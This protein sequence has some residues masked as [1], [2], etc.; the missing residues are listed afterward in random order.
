MKR[1]LKTSLLVLPLVALAAGPAAADVK[2][3]DKSQVKFEGFLGRMMGMFG[4][5]AA[6]E[7]IVT[8]NAVKGDRKVELSDTNGRIVDLKEEKVYELD[9]KK[10]TYEVL[11]FEEIRRRM[12][13]AQE[14]ARKEAPAEER[15]P[16]QQ[17]PQDKPA[18]EVDIDFD[19]KE[20][21]QTKSVAGYNAREV[22]MTVTVR[23]KGKA[24][25]DSGGLVISSTS[26]LAPAIPAMKEVAEFEMRYWKAIAPETAG[27]SAEQ[28]A[29][30]MAMYPML[31]QAMERLRAEGTKLE[32]TPLATST[33]FEAVKSKE[34]AAQ[35]SQ[36]NSGGG[37]GGMLAR[38][39][40]KRED[41]PRATILTITTETLE[42]TPNVAAEELQIPAGFKEKK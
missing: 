1:L 23:E 22:V 37:I 34:Q 42:V 16:Q 39:M 21:G 18:R 9:M 38:R 13:E 28:M 6:K 14:R 24:L 35:Q 32:G 41:K 19:V 27:I 7:G 8:T 30:V 12:R 15:E 40:T 11:T 31:K 17:Q 33:L 5:K 20:T 36:Q 10:K 29:A 25:E 26:W 2:T 3:R 4:G